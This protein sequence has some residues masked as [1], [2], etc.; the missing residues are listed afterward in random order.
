M[1]GNSEV[2]QGESQG[3]F[4]SSGIRESRSGFPPRTQLQQ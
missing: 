2:D 1:P 4:N 3:T